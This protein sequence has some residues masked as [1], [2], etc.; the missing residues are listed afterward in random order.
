MVFYTHVHYGL[1]AQWQSKRLLIVRF[2]VRLPGSPLL[3]NT[4]IT[5]GRSVQI[6]SCVLAFLMYARDLRPLGTAGEQKGPVGRAGED[7]PR[8]YGMGISPEGW[9]AT[10]ATYCIPVLSSDT[11]RA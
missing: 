1:L 3:F 6:L 8:P 9:K 5:R 11:I 2:R 10:R 7:E 4:P